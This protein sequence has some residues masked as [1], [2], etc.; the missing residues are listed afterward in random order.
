MK[1]IDQIKRDRITYKRQKSV[2]EGDILTTLLSEVQRLEKVDQENDDKVIG[3]INKY[4]KG[5]NEMILL[6]EDSSD[7]ENEK[8][9][10]SVYLPKQLTEAQLRTHIDYC[11]VEV[12]AE[13]VRDMGKVMKLLKEREGGLYDG[14]VASTIV[15][16]RLA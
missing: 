16:E 14:K 10:V 11:I 15:K 8:H 4:V 9:V 13:T 2:T 1:L 7:L 12:K 3:V 6:T 5:L